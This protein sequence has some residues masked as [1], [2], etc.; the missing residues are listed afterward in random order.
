LSSILFL[1]ISLF[2]Y[3]EPR[4]LPVTWVGYSE[5]S[6][7]SYYFRFQ[8]DS[9]GRLMEKHRVT[10]KKFYYSSYVWDHD[11]IIN[12]WR[13]DGDRNLRTFIIV[14]WENNQVSGFKIFDSELVPVET[15]VLVQNEK[16]QIIRY[17]YYDIV[18][19]KEVFRDKREWEYDDN[20]RKCLQRIYSSELDSITRYKYDH[21]DNLVERD[22]ESHTH[23]YYRGVFEF[24][25][26][27]Q[28]GTDRIL[29]SRSENW[30]RLYKYNEKNQLIA[31]EE[32]DS[33]LKTFD[34]EFY[35]IFDVNPDLLEMHPIYWG[36]SYYY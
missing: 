14:N 30:V 20:G 16:N 15:H 10:N 31:I 19:G 33:N 35:R 26:E 27:Y 4:S 1:F 3:S 11:R 23:G 6:D 17:E 32:M 2:L 29:S 25:N 34:Y 12:I 21:A 8:Y 22:I 24:T 7:F 28:E 36:H 5:A 18:D 13:Y 9:E